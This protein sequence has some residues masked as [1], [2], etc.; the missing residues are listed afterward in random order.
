MLKFKW[1][2]R[3]TVRTRDF[4]S[5]NRGSIPRTVTTLQSTLL[6]Y[7]HLMVVFL[8]PKKPLQK[9]LLSCE[10]FYTNDERS[11]MTSYRK[12]HKLIFNHY[13]SSIS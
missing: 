7:N 6:L 11:I 2:Y 5:C 4:Q 9:I 3:L 13:Y 1:P 12:R 8:Y 10:V